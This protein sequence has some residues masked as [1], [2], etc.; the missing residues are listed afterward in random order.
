LKIDFASKRKMRTVYIAELG[1]TVHIRSLCV[2]Q[3]DLMGEHAGNKAVLLSHLL[4]DENGER[5]YTTDEDLTNLGQMPLSAFM[6]INQVAEE[7]N[8]LS[9]PAKDNIEKK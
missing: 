3:L 8:N 5:I 7:L 2:D 4:V 6:K 9:G 1:E